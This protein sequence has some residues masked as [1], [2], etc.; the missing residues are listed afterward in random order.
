[1]HKLQWK[2]NECEVDELAKPNNYL[3]TGSDLKLRKRGIF[4]GQ[5]NRQKHI[6]KVYYYAQQ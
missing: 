1:M 6:T 3:L 5:K 4:V 2:S